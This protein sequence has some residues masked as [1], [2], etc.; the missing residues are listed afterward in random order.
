[1]IELYVIP[2]WQHSKSETLSSSFKSTESHTLDPSFGL[3]M[4]KHPPDLLLLV[5]CVRMG[6]VIQKY[7]FVTNVWYMMVYVPASCGLYM[8]VQ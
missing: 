6:L 8:L 1:M 5:L 3:N 4:V 2:S 7:P